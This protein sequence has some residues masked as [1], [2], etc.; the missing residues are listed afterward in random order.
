MKWFYNDTAYLFKA[1]KMQWQSAMVIQN[2]IL[3]TDLQYQFFALLSTNIFVICKDMLSQ[4]DLNFMGS[5]PKTEKT[6]SVLN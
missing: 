6:T 3:K 5:G 2:T 1:W 4:N